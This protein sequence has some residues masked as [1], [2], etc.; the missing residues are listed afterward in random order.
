MPSAYSVAEL[1]PVSHRDELLSLWSRNLPS[2][3]AARF[4]WMYAEGDARTWF[5][6][7]DESVPIGA[8]GLMKRTFKV[9][10]RLLPAGQAID[11]NVDREH[12][13]VGAALRLQRSVTETVLQDHL[14]LIYGTPN[15]QAQAVMRRVGYVALGNLQCWTKPLRSRSL[16]GRYLKWP[17][18]T[19]LAAPLVDIALKYRSPDAYYRRS[20]TVVT[21]ITTEFDDRFD[22]LWERAARQFPI[23]GER[24]AAYLNWRF[25]DCP[26]LDYRTL[27]L[28]DRNSGELM[29]YVV[30]CVCDSSLGIADLLFN[31]E[32]ACGVLLS[33]FVRVARQQRCC[34]IHMAFFGSS[35]LT[36]CLSRAGFFERPRD[37]TVMA[38]LGDND[39]W[40]SSPV[41]V[42]DQE[43]WFLTEADS[44]S[45]L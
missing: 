39:A 19:R 20:A 22:R 36:N 30:Y 3:T 1:E 26:E 14:S 40:N 15:K 25:R 6:S 29:G 18:A 23:M 43:N 13:S 38:H 4:D 42:R 35:R 24:S 37:F 41:D 12:R 2:A 27:C 8:A 9:G 33:E 5:A 7:D 31:D 11:M 21:E 28:L 34:A 32:R 44:D 45:D 10:D 17:M 16:L